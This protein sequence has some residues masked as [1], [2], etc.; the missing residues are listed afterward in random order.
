MFGFDKQKMSLSAAYN[1]LEA[2]LKLSLDFL[3]NTL[4]PEAKWALHSKFF[5]NAAKGF[6]AKRVMIL[7]GISACLWY[8]SAP[9]VNF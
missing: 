8:S 2:A 5:Y 7:I 6:K 4:D 3:K 1:K 9:S